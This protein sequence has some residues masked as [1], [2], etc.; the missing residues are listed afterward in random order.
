MIK[1]TIDNTNIQE[2]LT[3]LSGNIMSIHTRAACLC[4]RLDTANWRLYKLGKGDNDAISSEK[5][6]EKDVC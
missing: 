4:A 5:A 3:Y 2:A 6:K 1:L